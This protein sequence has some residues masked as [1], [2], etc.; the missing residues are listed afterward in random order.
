VFDGKDVTGKK[1]H[2]LAGMGVGRTFQITPFFS[3]FTTFEN[4]VASFYLS[5]DKS[6]W[7]PIL[8]TREYRR[9]EEDILKQAEE[10]LQL[11]GLGSVRDELAKNLPHGHQRVLD[12]ATALAVKP[13]LLLDEPIGGMGQ[14]EIGLAL[15]AIKEVRAQGTTI[16]LVEHNVSVVMGLCDRIVVINYGRKI[17]EGAPNEV[18]KNEEVIS[19]YFGGEYAA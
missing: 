1:P 15:N 11:V 8:A 13:R 12:L 7:R 2:V 6:L 4:I 5:A 18:R 9:R 10:N 14:E 3:E 17:A 19:A 16:L